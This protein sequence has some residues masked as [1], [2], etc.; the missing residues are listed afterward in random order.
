MEGKIELLKQAEIVASILA[1]RSFP[2]T[3]GATAIHHCC[4][5]PFSGAQ[6]II[7]KALIDKKFSL[8]Q[9]VVNRLSEWFLSFNNRASKDPLPLLWFQTFASFAKTYGSSLTRLP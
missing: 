7:L 6:N 4:S 2:N 8:P 1:R 5:V 3:H 9:V